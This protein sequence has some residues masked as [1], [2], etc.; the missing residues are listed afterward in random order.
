MKT[1][2]NQ[3][4][5]LTLSCLLLFSSS[6][7]AF[8]NCTP[9]KVELEYQEAEIVLPDGHMIKDYIA[10]KED[11]IFIPYT[12]VEHMMNEPISWDNETKTLNVGNIPTDTVMSDK[13]KIYHYDYDSIHAFLYCPDAK[14]NKPM[15]M[16]NEVHEAGYSFTN[17]ISAS[18]N[19]DQTYHQITGYLGCEDFKASSGQVNFYLDNTLIHT[20]SLKADQMPQKIE[21]DVT[22]GKQL[23]L[24]FTHF[25]PDTQINF[26][27][28]YIK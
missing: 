12:L 5:F 18:F 4:I 25:K 6:T 19:L 16:A 8:I 10:S 15:T 27:D 28:V 26:V 21:L 23:K 7:F 24:V 17:V 20:Q 9:K 14:T 22:D 13:L 3:K 2:L 11:E 1:L